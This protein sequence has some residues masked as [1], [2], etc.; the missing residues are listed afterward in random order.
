MYCTTGAGAGKWT[1]CLPWDPPTVH[2]DACSSTDRMKAVLVMIVTRLNLAA[3]QPLGYGKPVEPA[4]RCIETRTT[5][6][7]VG[8]AQY[9]LDVVGPA[10]LGQKLVVSVTTPRPAAEIIRF[11]DRSFPVT[12]TNRTVSK[13]S[14]TIGPI[15]EIKP[16]QQSCLSC[17][18]CPCF[19]PGCGPRCECSC[20]AMCRLR[21]ETTCAHTAGVLTPGR[22]FIAVDAPG[23]FALEATLVSAHALVPRARA[24]RRTVFSIGAASSG[25]GAFASSTS[26]GVAFSDY[27]YYDPAPHESLRVKVELIRTGGGGWVDVYVRFGDWP[28]VSENDAAMRCDTDAQPYAQFVLQPDR[29]LNERLCILIIGRGHSW[30]QYAISAR[31]ALS[32]PFL[33]AMSFSALVLLGASMLIG[34]IILRQRRL[35]AAAAAAEAKPIGIPQSI[36]GYGTTGAA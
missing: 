11:G 12:T 16:F 28:T 18:F 35:R 9:C 27:F 6:T 13:T 7:G 32:T 30:V 36:A 21:R 22:W 26:E 5:V 23:A 4:T 25:A 3:T 19:G 24:L 31:E 2:E 14:S 15:I 34:R 20:N 1:H 10:S 17:D 8:R 29:L 33:F